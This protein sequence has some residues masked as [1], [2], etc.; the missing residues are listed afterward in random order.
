MNIDAVRYK[1]Q[2]IASGGGTGVN[3]NPFARQRTRSTPDIETQSTLVKSRSEPS[4]PAIEEQQRLESAKAE[5]EFSLLP[6]AASAPPLSPT[7]VGSVNAP[8]EER[9][10]AA[11]SS[12]EKKE[13]GS[14]SDE[15]AVN[16]DHAGVHKR[17]KFKNIFRKSVEDDDNELRPV[18]S[19]GLTLEEKKHRAL[20]R[21]IPPSQQFKAVLF[22]SWINLLLV[23]VPVGFVV[24]YI[25]L[26]PVPV[27][28]INFIA[29]IPLAGMLSYATEELA[30]RV[31]ETFG[32]LL[33]ATFGYVNLKLALRAPLII[34]Q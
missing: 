3:Y 1:A 17:A 13:T 19:D 5:K 22:G 8:I 18:E 2:R 30:L 29:I 27:F 26:A 21:K 4:V 9:D 15:T 25:H 24:N 10:F 6:H 12:G 28:I 11:H 20:K 31:G 33:N 16:G 14:I 7:S 32:G 23:F 34:L